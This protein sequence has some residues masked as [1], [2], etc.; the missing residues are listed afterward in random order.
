[1]SIFTTAARNSAR[2]VAMVTR[3]TI[4]SEAVRIVTMDEGIRHMVQSDM[5]QAA[6]A[7]AGH[8]KLTAPPDSGWRIQRV[9]RRARLACLGSSDNG[10]LSFVTLMR[11]EIL[12][13][14]LP[15]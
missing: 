7:Q 6:P 10:E 9:A 13:L 8:D 5:F 2:A 3:R 15:F 11:R 12:I 4:K 1:M 14:L